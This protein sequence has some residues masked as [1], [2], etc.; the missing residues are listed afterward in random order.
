MD[1]IID[2]ANILSLLSSGDD[3][4]IF[5]YT[6]LIKR[7]IRLCFNFNKEEVDVSSPDGGKIMMWLSNL[8]HG[9]K[10]P[11]PVWNPTIVSDD[12]KSNFASSLSTE[13][14]RSIF[15]LDN[16]DVIPKI[17]EKG[18]ILIGSVGQEA[19]LLLSLTLEDTEV[20]TSKISSWIDYCP[21]LPLTDII[22]SDNH[23]FKDS[24][25]YSQNKDE[26]ISGLTQVVN[27]SPVNCVIVYKI[28]EVDNALNLENEV[29]TL[30]KSIKKITGSSKSS[31]TLIGTYSTHDRNAITNYYRIKNGSCFHLKDNGLKPDVTTE[32]KTHANIANE[33]RTNELILLYQ[34]IIDESKGKYIFGDK[35]SNFLKFPE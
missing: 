3:N 2:K 15:L 25:V 17:Q 23:F 28:N 1:L 26:L 12:I 27:Q 22:I 18:A 5:E 24:Y 35:K 29:D 11:L 19:E 21:A 13:Q 6:R 31:V 10:S 7:G 14:K 9:R 33:N 16:Q 4:A 34:R 20:A 30:K 8:A 32:I